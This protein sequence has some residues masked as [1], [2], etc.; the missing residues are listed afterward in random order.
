MSK[1]QR[2]HE[3]LVGAL[4]S[5]NVYFQPPETV[6]MQYPC[7]VYHRG[8]IDPRTAYADGLLYRTTKAYVVTVIDQDPDS[9]IPDRVQQLPYSR[10]TRS[11]TNQNLNHDVFTIYY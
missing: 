10:L 3:L 9:L 8:E 5:R 1:R 11:F 6:K 2:F 7:I 4:G